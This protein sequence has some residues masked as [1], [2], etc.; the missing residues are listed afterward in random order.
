MKKLS[1]ALLLLCAGNSFAQEYSFKK[2]GADNYSFDMKGKIVVQDTLITIESESHNP[3]IYP[4]KKEFENDTLKKFIS[5]FKALDANFILNTK[6]KTFVY[7]FKSPESEEQNS[8]LTY[9]LD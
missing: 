4:V 6:Q 5:S 1:L 8:K 3:S 2:I 9:L 7:E